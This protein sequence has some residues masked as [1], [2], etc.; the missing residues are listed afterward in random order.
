MG[1]ENADRI[2]RHV[3]QVVHKD[4]PTTAE[5]LNHVAIV[6]DL[7]KDVDGRGQE[8]QHLLYDFCGSN[9]SG[10]KAPRI[11]QDNLLDRHATSP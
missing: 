5:T 3:L 2:V 9:H 1:A 10:A 8:F 6:N 11:G 7:V 4:G